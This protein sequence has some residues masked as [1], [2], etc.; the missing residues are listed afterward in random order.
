[1]GDT[2]RDAWDLCLDPDLDLVHLCKE[3]VGPADPDHHPTRAPD[4]DLEVAAPL[5]VLEE[6]FP[7]L[8]GLEGSAVRAVLLRS[9]GYGHVHTMPR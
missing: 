2:S 8:V 1:M 4:A 7:L 9:W 5:D 6:P 3:H